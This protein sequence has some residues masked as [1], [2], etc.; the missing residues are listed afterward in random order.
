M[1][2]GKIFEVAAGRFRLGVLLTGVMVT[3]NL[4][5]FALGALGPLLVADLSVSRAD[6][7]L[8]ASTYY[9][10]AAAGSALLGGLVG[11][12]GA[13]RST[14][15][16]LGLG[17]VAATWLAAA[18]SYGWFFLGLALG[19]VVAA[20]AN[21]ATN[22]ALSA[23]P[24]RLGVLVGSKQSGVQGG[25]LLAGSLLPPV[26][27]VWGWQAAFVVCAGCYLLCFTGLP[28]LTGARPAPAPP[29]AATGSRPAGLVPLAAYAGCMGAGTSTVTTY[30]ALYGHEVVGLSVRVAGSLL[31][32]VGAVAVLAR[33]AWSVL[34]ERASRPVRGWL[35]A[36]I[37][38]IAVAA[39]GVLSLGRIGGPVVLWA[40]T[41]LVGVSAAAWNGVVMLMVIRDLPAERTAVVSG[42]VQAAFFVGLCVSPPLFG[43]LVDRY[44]GYGAGWGWS[45]LCFL[46]AG[47]A[48][49]LTRTRWN[50]PPVI[51]GAPAGRARAHRG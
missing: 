47:V 15:F 29:G 6:L 25:A 48:A 18:D 37:A 12:A 2:R 36:G 51:A 4:I 20:L 46:A 1:P 9:L 49:L 8:L 45:G 31:A 23:V 35:L 19:G 38:G 44:G 24:G 21:P 42:R 40:G 16:M 17:T 41:L 43:V 33:I 22:L 26:A 11:R 39:A 28:L 50:G 30:L 14:A 32:V 34:A 7:G 3:S 5:V 27:V 10:C 13:R